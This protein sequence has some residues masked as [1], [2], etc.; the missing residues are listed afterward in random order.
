M[1]DKIANHVVR[2][3]KV[4]TVLWAIF[5]M[6]SVPLALRYG[7]VLVYEEAKITPDNLESKVA[8]RIIAKEFP[9]SVPNGSAVFVIQNDNVTTRETKHFV[10]NLTE[11]IKSSKEIALLDK[12]TTVYSL[13]EDILYSASSALASSYPD[14][15]A[16]VN[17]SGNLLYGIPDNFNYTC[18]NANA[19]A[20]MLYGFPSNYIFLWN[21]TEQ[22]GM[23]VFGLPLQ[24]AQLWNYTNFSATLVYT[25]PKAHAALW[26]SS[27][28][29]GTTVEEKDNSTY[30]SI[31]TYM[32]AMLGQYGLNETEIEMVH[33][34]Y[35]LF[36]NYWN[37][38]SSQHAVG[39]DYNITLERAQNAIDH[40][41]L[42]D[43]LNLTFN[44]TEEKEFFQ[45]I[46][47]FWNVFTWNLSFSPLYD[48]GTNAPMLNRFAYNLITENIGSFTDMIPQEFLPAINNY[49]YSFYENWSSILGNYSTLE[50]TAMSAGN[51]SR[52]VLFAEFSNLTE[53]IYPD[54]NITALDFL[55]ALN[56][57]F[58][59]VD[60][61]NRS[62]YNNTTAIDNFTYT[63][64]TSIAM[65]DA[66]E[67]F[68]NYSAQFFAAWN[69][70]NGS[71]YERMLN[72]SAE[73]IPLFI[74]HIEDNTTR[75]FFDSVAGNI[76][77]STWESRQALDNF[78]YTYILAEI[79]KSAGEYFNMTKGYL[80]AFYLNW[81]KL[82]DTQYNDTTNRTDIVL[83]GM[84]TTYINTTYQGDEREFLLSLTAWFNLK[85]YASG[86][87]HKNFTCNYLASHSPFKDAGYISNLVEC[88]NETQIR[89]LVKSTLENRGMWDLPMELHPAIIHKLVSPD[90]KTIL[91][92][93]TFLKGSNNDSVS[94]NV[95]VLREIASELNKNY[96]YSVYL[97][98]DVPIYYDVA[99][100]SWGEVSHID[101]F[102][103]AF[104][105]IF[106]L[107]YFLSIVAPFIP[108][109]TVGIV[110]LIADAIIFVVGT[111]LMQIYYIVPT[112]LFTVLLGAGTDYTI[113]IL[114]RYRE[115]RRKGHRKEE[116]IKTAVTWAGESIATSGGTVMISFGALTISSLPLVQTIGGIVFIGIAIGVLA[117][118]TLL[119]ALVMLVGDR[120]FWPYKIKYT[121]QTH[122]K[123]SY[124]YKAAHFSLK[125]AK[126]IVLAA[127]L[128]T[129]PALYAVLTIE[130]GYD[131]ISTMPDTEGKQGMDAMGSSFG[132]GDIMPTY[133][134]INLTKP[135]RNGANYDTN[136]FNDTEKLCTDIEKT[137]GITK[138]YSIT[139]PFGDRI[140]YM[141]AEELSFYEPVINT[142]IGQNAKTMLITI[143]LEEQPFHA[144]A[145]KKVTEIRELV[146][147]KK[148]QIESFRDA[149]FYFTGSTA[150][151]QDVKAV[152]DHDFPVMMLIV[153]A[154]AYIV[155]LFVLGSVLI[156]LR[157]IGVTLMTATWS[158]ALT[159]F[160]FTII[161]NQPLLWLMPL[162][163][164]V[165]LVG[166]GLDYDI[167]LTTRI[168]EEVTKGKSD[169]EAIT[170]AVERTGAIITICGLIMAGALGSMMISAMGMLKQFGFALCAGI[171]IDTAIMRIYL[172]P[173][174]MILLKKW[175]WWAPGRLQRVKRGK[176]K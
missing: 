72:A 95:K 132:K 102:A 39:E 94:N 8:D 58:D 89:D 119:P 35:N 34:Y 9:D 70:T 148:A 73:A 155:L 74:A 97:T 18:S 122:D 6:L 15:N 110:I 142:S 159:M 135:I 64:F 137:G 27:F 154:G 5:L 10:E 144:N 54:I 57:T 76:T 131:F 115:E 63:M 49:T 116:A 125:Y 139:R 129:L 149:E 22:S 3:Y 165:V 151:M 167:L 104:A 93:I 45:K 136:I 138:I 127:F 96:N 169:E 31:S 65:S 14:I 7:D 79:R 66:T 163:L 176:T 44:T 47:E 101:T 171:L 128:I 33:N 85:N 23:L 166:L 40:N 38:T 16:S 37:A 36:A 160:V 105:I 55:T 109:G 62:A 77:F 51:I 41:A 103:V 61:P 153:L 111:F 158:L 157:L 168:R 20:F 175:N 156:P 43:W 11:K 100:S 78:T 4:I 26:N 13:E 113:F 21:M 53:P 140:N 118:L 117:A 90:N 32:D 164:F 84:L 81:T 161:L 123:N 83:T 68:L 50:E 92:S 133:I 152:M 28:T 88:K 107:I 141:D 67:L 25:L 173:S 147:D 1:F 162:I 59:Y 145:M 69:A 71:T 87:E 120:V 126:A 121:P 174:M 52:S 172:V 108:L 2:R 80:D 46:H 30:T 60:S 42:N 98:G 86:S 48:E 82:N 124:F 130:T 170:T 99:A 143:V 134:V 112:L 114:S 106:M 75:E 17:A 19:I 56:T 24:Y 150:G 146:K 91:V 12:I 29:Q